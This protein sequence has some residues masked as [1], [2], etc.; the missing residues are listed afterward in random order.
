MRKLFN[1]HGDISLAVPLIIDVDT[2]YIKENIREETVTDI[3]DTERKEWVWDET[4]YTFGE[5]MDMENK[6]V[7]DMQM[8]TSSLSGGAIQRRVDELAAAAIIMQRQS[9]L[10]TDAEALAVPLAHEVWAENRPYV[11]IEQVIR[12]PADSMQLY[13]IKSPVNK[14]LAHQPPGSEGMLSVYRPIDIAHDGTLTD[15]IPYVYGM[16]VLTGKYYLFETSLWRAK[17][18]MLPCVWPPSG[19]LINEWEHISK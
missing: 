13:R 19:A 12:H 5:Y 7:T 2:V 17:K 10:L 4:Q 11:I 18:D 15:P 3:S 8:A 14:S 9:H 1:V 16:D 6:R